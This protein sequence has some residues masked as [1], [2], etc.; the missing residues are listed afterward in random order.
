ME[1]LNAAEDPRW[2]AA[3]VHER[4]VRDDPGVGRFTLFLGDHRLG[5]AHKSLELLQRRSG[6]IFS[7][8]SPRKREGGTA[9]DARHCHVFASQ[10][11]AHHD[12]A[13]HIWCAGFGTVRRNRDCADCERAE[14]AISNLTVEIS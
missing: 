3:A 5:F 6:I 8:R 14:E 4:T 10:P 12:D 2:R 13:P 7:S 9:E 1:S 11:A